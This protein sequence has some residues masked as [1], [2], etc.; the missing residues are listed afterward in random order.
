MRE[1][2]ISPA[3][4]EASFPEAGFCIALAREGLRVDATE[5]PKACAM[6]A[7]SRRAPRSFHYGPALTSV[8]R[9]T[10]PAR[11]N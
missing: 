7:N 9:Y 2:D 11:L 4:K 5:L 6:L 1:R 10:L 8:Q 3:E